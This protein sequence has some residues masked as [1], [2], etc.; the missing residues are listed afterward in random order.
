MSGNTVG[1]S[2]PGIYICYPNRHAWD[3]RNS[4]CSRIRHRHNPAYNQLRHAQNHLSYRKAHPT[5]R[6]G[7]GDDSSAISA[8][9]HY[10]L[11]SVPSTGSDAHSPQYR[12]GNRQCQILPPKKQSMQS[13]IATA[14]GFYPCAKPGPTGLPTRHWLCPPSS[15]FFFRKSGIF[16]GIMLSSLKSGIP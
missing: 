6:Q 8:M 13:D 3:N 11:Y 4:P 12:S 14:T 10:K 5:L 16:T 7:H 9:Q 2:L 1:L 15:I